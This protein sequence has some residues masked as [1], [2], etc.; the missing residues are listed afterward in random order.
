MKALTNV[1]M[2]AKDALKHKKKAKKDKIGKIY[3]DGE[4]LEPIIKRKKSVLNP[5]IK[6]RKVIHLHPETHRL[7]DPDYRVIATNDVEEMFKLE[8][9]NEATD[10]H[11]VCKPSAAVDDKDSRM[12]LLE[13]LI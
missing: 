7:D 6:R 4:T 10:Q 2:Q 8:D 3:V 13:T 12:K 11:Y 5:N 1:N 9:F